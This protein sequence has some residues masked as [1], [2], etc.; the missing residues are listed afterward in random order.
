MLLALSAGS[1]M[2]AP[3]LPH[4]L[5][6]L[7][8]TLAAPHNLPALC[9]EGGA[10]VLLDSLLRLRRLVQTGGWGAGGAAAGTEGQEA[11]PGVDPPDLDPDLDLDDDVDLGSGVAAL[12]L[13]TQ[14]CTQAAVR[15]LS[16]GAEVMPASALSQ[17][18]HACCAAAADPGPHLSQ[19]ILPLP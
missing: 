16:A 15:E 11:G 3:P 1:M 13:A 8:L 6:R 9:S 19:V 18:A 4:S 10:T 14:S 2:R 17:L 7:L 12:L 5:S